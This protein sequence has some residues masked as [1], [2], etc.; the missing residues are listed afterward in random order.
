MQLPSTIFI[1][2]T[3]QTAYC[4]KNHFHLAF[5][6]KRRMSRVLNHGFFHQNVRPWPLINNINSNS[7]RNSIFYNA[8]GCTV[9][10]V[11]LNCLQNK[12]YE[13]LQKVKIICKTAMLWKKCK[14][15]HR[16]QN[17]WTIRAALVAF[18]GNIYQ[19]QNV[20][21]LSYPPLQKY[22]NLMGLPNT[23]CSSMRCHWHWIQKENR[24][25]KILW[26]FPFT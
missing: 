7:R 18:K 22:R 14:I 25:W 19:K 16:M 17:R 6:F 10:A 21:E 11:S 23:K 2:S 1:Y 5:I 24:R 4:I 26:H 15:W 9:H 13:Q 3:V 12:I 8:S 20:S